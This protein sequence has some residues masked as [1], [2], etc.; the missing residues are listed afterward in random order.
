MSSSPGPEN[1]RLGCFLLAALVCF[2]PSQV[3]APSWSAL[4]SRTGIHHVEFI[5]SPL[6]RKRSVSNGL[7]YFN[8]IFVWL[9]LSSWKSFF[10]RQNELLFWFLTCRL[11]RPEVK[12][13]RIEAWMLHLGWVGVKFLLRFAVD[14]TALCLPWRT[15]AFCLGELYLVVQGA[16][17]GWPV[18]H[19]VCTVILESSQKGFS[20]EDAES[21]MDFGRQ[22]PAQRFAF[23]PDF[24]AVF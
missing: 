17:Q 11:L 14:S 1:F 9:V 2:H 19:A 21:Q 20:Q 22:P 18:A 7:F 6:P 24:R 15:S 10:L 23:I 3:R 4:S 13:G 12:G 16:P 8:S 5:L